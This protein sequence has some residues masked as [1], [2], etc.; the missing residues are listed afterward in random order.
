MSSKKI[1]SIV[2]LIVCSFIACMYSSPSALAAISVDGDMSDWGISPGPYGASNWEP[3]PGIFRNVNDQNPDPYYGYIGPGWGGQMYDVEAIYFTRDEDTAY[4]AVVS[5][6]PLSGW[7]GASFVPGDLAIDFVSDAALYEFGVE[8]TGIQQGMVFGSATWTNPV[9]AQH[10]ECAPVSLS[11]GTAIGKADFGYNPSLYVANGHYAFE[12]GIPL[13]M[14]GA[15]WSSS[16]Y[17]S[18]LSAHWTM[19]CGNNCLN[20]DVPNVS[21]PEPASVLLM[22]SGLGAFVLRK[23][24]TFFSA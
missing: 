20:L 22:M 19:S 16:L 21:V 8:T 3:N 14:F 18:G 23:R 1:F 17:I 2:C 7:P 10:I 5:G 13:W 9:Y 24:K 4:F 12:V 15:Y 6:F 11:G